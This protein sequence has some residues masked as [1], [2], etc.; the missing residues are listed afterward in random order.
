V[1]V[2]RP[3]PPGRG[4]ARAKLVGVSDREQYL[5][6]NQQAEAARRFEALSEL[7]DWWTFRHISA[8]GVQEGWRCW[9]VGAGGPA[10]PEWLA[11]QVGGRGHVLATDI[12]TSLLA[13]SSVEVRRHDIGVDA[14]PGDGFDLIHARLVLVHVPRRAEA[15]T[16]MVRSLRPGGWL[17]IEEA[18][19]ALQPKVCV[20]EYGPDQRLANKLKDAF[21]VL[22]AERGV[23]LA[24]GR[25]LPR[26]LREEG[27]TDVAAEACFPVT[28]P[29]C[30]LLEEATV[31]Q[32][33]D[34]VLTA[35]LATEAEIDRHLA[36]VRSGRLDLT[37]S[38][39]ISAWGRK[40]FRS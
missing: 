9:E 31:L 25:T 7:F 27:L 35:G 21:R 34:R 28:N 36:N 18:D 10:V 22:M 15:L 6:G 14:P 5:L 20:D 38:P 4:T 30:A 11:R 16:A 39:L 13:T 33:R 3:S 1:A 8:L 24:Y 29:A 12:D 40:R 32:T 37:I 26:L 23:D 17:L 2:P 19:P